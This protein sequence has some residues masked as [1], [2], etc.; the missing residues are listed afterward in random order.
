MTQEALIAEL[1]AFDADGADNR[2]KLRLAQAA[3]NFVI[4]LLDEVADD[5]DNEYA[6]AYLVDQLKIH[7]S[8]DHGFLAR[9]FNLDQWVESLDDEEDTDD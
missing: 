4:D 6:R 7:A 9:D 1:E 5:T 3:L 2:D 8:A